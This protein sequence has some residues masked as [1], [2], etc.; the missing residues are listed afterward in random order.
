MLGDDVA[1]QA[2]EGHE[3]DEGSASD[4]HSL[5]DGVGGGDGW[6]G[7]VYLLVRDL[8]CEYGSYMGQYMGEYG[9]LERLS[10]DGILFGVIKVAL[11]LT[12]S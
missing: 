10:G 3:G 12:K 8:L 2:Q 5:D 1:G 9:C 4:I 7:D 6:D 11:K